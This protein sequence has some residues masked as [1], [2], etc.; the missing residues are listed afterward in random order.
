MGESTKLEVTKSGLFLDGKPFY[1]ASGSMHYFRFFKGG[2][3][4]RLEL[5]K[6]FGLNAVQ[7]YVPWNLHEPEKGKFCFDDNLDIASFLKLCQEVG[8]KVLLRPSPYMCS[9]WDFG[10]LPYWLL[11]EQDL[12]VRTSCPKYLKHV[13]EYYERLTREYVPYL[14]TNG[15]P[16]IAV[17][18]ENEYGSYSE[19][20]DYLKALGDM[21]KENGVDVPLYTSDGGMLKML[22]GGTHPEYWAGV[23]FHNYTDEVRGD[24]KR[25][26]PNQASLCPEFYPGRAQKWGVPFDRQK[27]NELA[28]KYKETLEKDI[29]INF[30]MFCGGTNFGFMN[31]GHM[32]SDETTNYEKK[33]LPYCTSYDVD[34]LVTEEGTPTEKYFLCKKA[35]SDFKKKNRIEDTSS[36]KTAADYH[37][38]TQ[39]PEDIKFAKTADLFDNIENIAE[40]IVNSPMPLSFESLDQPYGFVLYRA[41]INK[42]DDLK[43]KVYIDGLKDR[44]VI[45][46]NGKYLGTIRD[47]YNTET[48]EFEI[49]EGG[50]TLDILVENLG[51]NCA[52]MNIGNEKK[53]IQNYVTLKMVDKDGNAFAGF[54]RVAG[55]EHY[56]L[57]MT[58]LSKLDYSKEAK[59]ERPAFYSAEFDAKE[60]VDTF[61]NPQG[62]HKGVIFVNGFNLGRYWKIGPQG[63]LY[64]PGELI[65]KHN[66][67]TVLE[68]HNPGKDNIIS[69]SDKAMIDME[70]DSDII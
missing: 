51:R 63:T 36:P 18:V 48:E 49:P 25:L 55:W 8:L 68:L 62:W 29:Y 32:F 64:I 9:E 17:C 7:T 31:G 11:K 3:R 46:G 21:L 22:I 39:K 13:E 60:G 40:K 30:Y 45:F 56:S 10:G 19:D 52:S 69:F 38:E 41:F 12:F 14:S 26:F 42:T 65:K 27:P 35:L 6:D 70:I 58:D 5:M 2:W 4:R 67:I 44:A 47:Y 57:P 59:E 1:L 50:M 24:Y 16:I 20:K 15:G 66:T 61:I 33:F 37:H 28:D 54:G 34:S 43:R 23:N 53:G